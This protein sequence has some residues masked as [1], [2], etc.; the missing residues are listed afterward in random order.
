MSTPATDKVINWPEAKA[1]NF[2]K[3]NVYDCKIVEKIII[4]ASPGSGSGSDDKSLKLDLPDLSEFTNLTH[5]YLWKIEGLTALPALPAGLKCL[6]VRG[7][8]ELERITNLPASLDTLVLDGCARLSTIPAFPTSTAAFPKLEEVSLKGC[9]EV[10]ETWI[11]GL[12]QAAPQ[13]HSFNASDCPQLTRIKR[14]PAPLERIELNGCTGLTDLPKGWP[15]ALYRLGLHGAS[16]LPTLHEFLPVGRQLD[17]LDLAGTSSLT[18]LPE[19]PLELRTLFLFGSGVGLA[20]ELFGKSESTNVA[21][22]VK[23]YLSETRLGTLADNEVKVIFL[24]NGRCGKS[25]VARRLVGGGFD[26][27]Q[28]TTHG[29]QLWTCDL[30]FVPEDSTPGERATARLNIWDFAGQDLYH[31]THRLFLQ[32]KAVFVLCGT[33]HGKGADL[34]GDQTDD[35]ELDEGEDFERDMRY[36]WDQEASLG[37]APG[38]GGPPPI[39][40]VRTKADRDDENQHSAADYWQALGIETQGVPMIEF[41]AREGGSCVEE[42]REKLKVAVAQVLGQRGRRELGRRPMEVKH[43]LQR[44]KGANEAEFKLATEMKRPAVLRYPTMDR[45]VF[46]EIV[47][48]YVPDGAYYDRPELLLDFLHQ[49]GFLYFD[50]EHLPGTVILDQRWAVGGMYGAFRRK[51]AWRN[52]LG[53]RGRFTAGDLADWS[54]NR[55]DPVSGQGPFSTDE[56][57]LFLRFMLAC[58]MCFELRSAGEGVGDA[59]YLLP[60]ALPLDSREMQLE[61]AAQRGGVAQFGEKVVI[62]DWRLGRDAV[63]GLMVRLGRDWRRAP[64]LWRWGGQFRSYRGD[65]WN[66]SP[67]FVLLDWKEE[68]KNS[69]GGTLGLTLYGPD[70]SFLAALVNECRELA[71]F[72]GII[73]PEVK[74]PAELENERP[75]PVDMELEG[76]RIERPVEATQLAAHKG[77]PSQVNVVEIGISFAGDQGG[78]V[79][80]WKSLP[81]TSIE[82]WPLALASILKAPPLS[83]GVLQ[84]RDEQMKQEHHKDQGR[85]ALLDKV[86]SRDFVVLF[87]SEDSLKSIW[88]MYELMRVFNRMSDGQQNPAILRLGSFPSARFSQTNVDERHPNSGMGPL[89]HYLKLW[90]DWLPTFY[91]R[92]QA[93]V[94]AFQQNHNTDPVAYEEV[95]NLFAYADWVR[96]ARQEASLKKLLHGLF[97][98]WTCLPIATEPSPSDLASWADEIAQNIGRPQVLIDFAEWAWEH[99]EKVRALNLYD[100]AMNLDPDL[101][102]SGEQTPSPRRGQIAFS[103]LDLIRHASEAR[104]RATG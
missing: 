66:S 73:L 91:R 18:R 3:W 81:D 45:E 2:G 87:L 96:F 57:Q 71:S 62:Q 16:L 24:G 29:I 9:Q 38:M 22:G 15:V 5:L 95:I 6:D 88:C 50:Q 23:A 97:G 8:Q 52:L 59:E 33:Q 1:K 76:R 82:K 70:K 72:R 60:S 90:K 84:Y 58:G 75:I 102:P 46:A 42:L 12:L 37:D 89:A 21:A 35:D 64:V 47:R 69:F 63:L 41:S 4:G 40:L 80:N 100:L 103:T 68:R 101:L 61:A 10:N 20:P 98:A 74:V 31:N 30:E 85:K 28:P 11:N 55:V 14:W 43:E 86:A 49:S 36:W 54:W 94:P 83:F 27:Q 19:L 51:T 48:R 78:P 104:K 44:L 32:S 39:L 13:L 79:E 92:I 56:Q 53:T 65:D 26:A 67:T 93:D 25:S 99:D 17:Y 34:A 77:K 7:C